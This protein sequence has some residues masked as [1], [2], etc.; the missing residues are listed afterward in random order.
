MKTNKGILQLQISRLLTRNGFKI[1]CVL[2]ILF[3]FAGYIETCFSV[4]GEDQAN[5]FSAAYGWLGNVNIVSENVMQIFY[6]FGICILAA[7]PFSDS[8]LEDKLG[9]ILPAILGR[10]SWKSY[11]HTGI[12]LTFLSGFT[13]IFIPLLISLF[14][15]LI[16]FPV[17]GDLPMGDWGSGAWGSLAI[18][19]DSYLFPSLVFDHPYLNDIIFIFYSSI[20]AGLNAVGSYILSLLGVRK[21][22]FVLCTP[23]I[24][25]LL[26]SSIMNFIS[27]K[28]SVY[29]YLYPNDSVYKEVWFFFVLPIILLLLLIIGYVIVRKKKMEAIL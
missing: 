13:V 14:L 1:A 5:L 19:S 20:F 3:I 9:R 10:C 29:I 8:F 28:L 18:L 23:T 11:L 24:L 21:K 4:W 6:F 15:S 26:Y 17:G 25:L 7:L 2:S 12:I 16:M 22:L 27:N